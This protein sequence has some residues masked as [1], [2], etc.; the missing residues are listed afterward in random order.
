MNITA[1]L[2]FLHRASLLLALG[3]A[4]LPLAHAAGD[5]AMHH[6]DHAMHTVTTAL[7][8]AAADDAHAQHRQA[9]NQH[10]YQRAVARYNLPSLTLTDSSGA[11]V[12]IA[13]LLDTEQPTVVNFIFTSCTTICPVM[14]A[15]FMQ[16]QKQLGM[17]AQQIQWISISID[18]EYDTPERLHGYAQRFDAGP[19]WH[20]L[21]G[22]L[23]DIIAV[24]KSFAV[25]RGDKM[26]HAPT[27]LLRVGRDNAWLRLDGLTSGAELAQEYHQLAHRH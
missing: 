6:H 18:P 11:T 26:N 9:M 23:D 16:A 22:T 13:Q 12:D 21:T 14:S 4:A 1:H 8:A 20:F 25:Y 17:D 19:N 15:T 7:P 3:C 2:P 5:H 27:T 10:G 24:Q